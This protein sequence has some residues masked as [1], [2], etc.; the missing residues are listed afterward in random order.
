MSKIEVKNLSKS[1]GDKVVLNNVSQ[2]FSPGSS[3]VI[4][5]KS[6]IGKSVFIKSIVGI[7]KPDE[8]SE[9]LIDDVLIDASNDEYFGN[10]GFLFQ[11]NALFDSLTVFENV[12]FRQIF[13]MNKK[14]S[15]LKD[16]VIDRL[17]F[18]GLSDDILHLKPSELSGG[19]QK[20]VALARLIMQNPSTI[21]LDEPTTGLD[22]IMS[23]LIGELALKILQELKATMITITHDM[24]IAKKLGQKI[25]FMNDGSFVWSGS[26]SDI[27]TTSDA[28][29]S[30]FVNGDL[31]GPIN[32]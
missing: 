6:G 5:G 17:G 18:V 22:P 10:I 12:A 9:I 1:F 4:L 32:I 3:S 24:K 11:N 2:V 30:Q 31:I 20:R 29:I 27:E 23:E 16:I 19:M 13:V 15:E 14:R 28:Y 21:F 25:L 7:V 26:K 8:N